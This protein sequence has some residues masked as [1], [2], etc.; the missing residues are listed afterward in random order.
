MKGG[1]TELLS[2]LDNVMVTSGHSLNSV[3]RVTQFTL[4]LGLIRQFAGGPGGYL[5][6]TVLTESVPRIA[7]PP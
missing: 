5:H 3:I 4:S 7:C 2:D 1:E 6:P